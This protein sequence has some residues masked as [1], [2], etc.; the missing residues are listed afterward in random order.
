MGKLCRGGD[1]GF[2]KY[3]IKALIALRRGLNFLLLPLQPKLSFLSLII[4]QNFFFVS[5]DLS[6]LRKVRKISL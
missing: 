1:S 4:S 6:S 2:I 3:R 5:N